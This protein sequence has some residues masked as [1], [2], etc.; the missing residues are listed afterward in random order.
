MHAQQFARPSTAQGF[1]AHA[2]ISSGRYASNNGLGSAVG[3]RSE[4]I[5]RAP[6]YRGI[7]PGQHYFPSHSIGTLYNVGPRYG[8]GYSTGGAYGG[9]RYGGA[10]SYGAGYG[11]YG[12]YRGG[13]VHSGNGS[14]SSSSSEGEHEEAP[15]HGS[16]SSR[17]GGFRGGGGHG[18]GGGGHGGGGH[19]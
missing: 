14:S 16:A 12:G 11:A 3:Y 7:T 6:Q 18:G 9:G 10:P 13:V 19:R 1:G 5:G 4:P 2:S 17:G 8:S 15:L